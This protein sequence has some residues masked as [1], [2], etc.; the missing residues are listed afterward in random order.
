MDLGTERLE[1]AA[2]IQE[3]CFGKSSDEPQ[4]RAPRRPREEAGPSEPDEGDEEREVHQ[5]NDIA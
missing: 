2:R 3:R 1:G 4:R 5:V